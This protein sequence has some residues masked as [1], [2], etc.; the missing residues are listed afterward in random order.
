MKPTILHISPGPNNDPHNPLYQSQY[1]ELSK[2][3]RGHIFTT[4]Y[5]KETLHIYDFEYSSM[6]F[7]SSKLRVFKFLFFCIWNVLKISLRKERIDLVVTYDP[8]S[9]GVIGVIVAGLLRTKFAPEVKGVYTS[10]SEWLDNADAL[11]TKL[12]KTIYPMIMRFVLKRA[13]GIM[14]LFKGQIDPFKKIIRGKIIHDFHSFVPVESFKNIREDKEILFV[15]FPFKRKGVDILIEAFKKI[16]PHNPQWKLKI[17]GW[18]PDLEELKNAIGGHSQIYYH[19]PVPHSEMPD[20]IGTCGILVLPSRSE[21]MGRVLV[22]A[23]AAGKPRIGT[24]VD[25]I[26]T[27]INDYVDG[28]LCNSEN[29]D[30]LATNWID[31]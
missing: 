6:K 19:H 14:I 25:G 9:T 21:A 15:G 12:K 16:A 11:E 5:R 4:A 24:H 30:D 29:V 1:E 3:F 23:M 28:L 10:P 27:V 26:P 31:S 20:H 17:L 22:E 7:S 18:Y 13:D 2:T 8:L